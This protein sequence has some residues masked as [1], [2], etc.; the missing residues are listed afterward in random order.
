[1]KP[2]SKIISENK[3]PC[4]SLT[5]NDIIGLVMGRIM[6]NIRMKSTNDLFLTYI[7]NADIRVPVIHKS[8]VGITITT[9]INNHH[10]TLITN[11]VGLEIKR[12]NIIRITS[13]KLRIIKP[14]S[15][16]LR[17]MILA[18]IGDEISPLNVPDSFSLTNSLA[19]TKIRVKKITNQISMIKI[20]LDICCFCVLTL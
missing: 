16:L 5:L 18:E 2:N 20:S 17:K 6:G 19:T 7:E 14:N 3:S 4:N 10:G 8:I 13:R 11:P 12:L 15:I 1:M 9:M